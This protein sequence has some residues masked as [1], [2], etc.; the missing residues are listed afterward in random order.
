MQKEEDIFYDSLAE[1]TLQ[2]SASD[3]SLLADQLQAFH[4]TERRDPSPPTPAADA[5]SLWRFLDSKHYHL[6]SDERKTEE[7]NGFVTAPTTPQPSDAAVTARLSGRDD[8]VFRYL[9]NTT[10]PTD[11]DRDIYRALPDDFSLIIINF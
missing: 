10:T 6:N 8:G 5:G 2:P 3:L 11:D 4:I 7:E 9:R 1:E